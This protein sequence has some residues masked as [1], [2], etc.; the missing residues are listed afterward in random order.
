MSF[1]ITIVSSCLSGSSLPHHVFQ[2]HSCVIM[3]FRIFIASSC[4]LSGSPLSHHD[5]QDIIYLDPISVWNF[6]LILTLGKVRC[7]REPKLSCRKHCHTCIVQGIWID[8][9]TVMMNYGHKV[10]NLAQWDLVIIVDHLLRWSQL[11]PFMDGFL[12]GYSILFCK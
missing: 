4:W 9:C 5:F 2:D 8:K 12:F 10:L 6:M 7:Y 1:R 3:S 11:I